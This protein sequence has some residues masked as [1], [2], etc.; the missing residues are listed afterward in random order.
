M[1]WLSH[2]KWYMNS[3]PE[4]K[5][6]KMVFLQIIAAWNW[7]TDFVIPAIPPQNSSVYLASTE[8]ELLLSTFM[9]MILNLEYLSKWFWFSEWWGCCYFHAPKSSKAECYKNHV[10]TFL[11]EMWSVS[12]KSLCALYDDESEEWYSRITKRVGCIDIEVSRLAIVCS[13]L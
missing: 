6:S 4:W 2:L 12:S 3:M 1:N 5:I 13:C 9:Q 7:E 11:P 8:W 10:H